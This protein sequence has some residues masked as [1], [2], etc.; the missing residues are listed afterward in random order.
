LGVHPIFFLSKHLSLALEFGVSHIDDEVNERKG[1]LFEETVILQVSTARGFYNRPVLRLFVT[2][3]QWG[4]DFKGLIESSPD[5][6]AYVQDKGG[7][8]TVR[9]VVLDLRL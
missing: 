1:S 4:D 9:V 8:P 3:A 2:H 5:D 6:A 7:W